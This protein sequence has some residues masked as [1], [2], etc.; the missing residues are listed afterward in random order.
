MAHLSIKNLGP[1][2]ELELDVKQFNI[3]IG[4]QATGK[5]IVCKSI[6]FFRLIKSILVD[7]LYGIVI[8]GYS[9]NFFPKVVNR[10]IKDIFVQ[11]FGYSWDLPE[12]MHMSYVYQEDISMQ[13]FLHKGDKGKYISLK[14]DE[15]LKNSI[16]TLENEAYVNYE[17]LQA[18]S[19]AGSSSFVL[20]ERNRAP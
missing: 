17:S 1:I 13:V 19:S 10:P 18:L 7:Y 14:Y 3:L 9:E 5:S 16:H 4:E 20:N 11:L 15:K 12:N 8:D 2:R 6:Y